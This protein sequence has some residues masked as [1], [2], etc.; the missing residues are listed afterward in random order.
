MLQNILAELV[1]VVVV[2][3][4]MNNQLELRVSLAAVCGAGRIEWRRVL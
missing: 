2:G 3:S 4:R 1:V